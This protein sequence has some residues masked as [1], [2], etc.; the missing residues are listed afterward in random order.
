MS[1][2]PKLSLI[3]NFSDPMTAQFIKSVLEEAG[4]PCFLKDL[5]FNFPT[6]FFDQKTA[7]IKLFVREEDLEAAEALLSEAAEWNED[8]ATEEEE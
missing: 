5:T 4:I 1:K 6:A 7:G 2:D 8:E 3:R